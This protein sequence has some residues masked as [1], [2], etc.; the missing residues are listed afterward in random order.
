MDAGDLAFFRAVASAGGMSKAAVMLNTVQSNVTQRIRLLETELGVPLFHRHTRGVSL[1]SAG[2]Q[3]LPYAERIGRLIGEAKQAAADGPVPRGRIVIGSLE[4]TAALRLPPILAAYAS[5]YP[6]VDIE[7]D[8]GTSAELIEAVLAHKVEAA[9]VVGPVNHPELV[10]LPMI[11][12]E[13]VLV[14]ASWIEDLGALQASRRF[15]IIVFRAGCTYRVHLEA[16]LA[17]QGIVG[18]RRLEFGTLEG[19]IGCVGA[20]I[21]VTLL[22]RAVVAAAAA[23]GRVALHPL[24]PQDARAETVLV[25]RRDAFASS[26]LL[27]F[28]EK[29]TEVC[30]GKQN[31]QARVL[32]KVSKTRAR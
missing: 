4:T 7:I 5:T 12:E 26:A 2:A 11:E 18:L 27:R 23:E 32:Q 24:P 17:R 6:D 15:K 19:I 1:T 9:F 13:L 22:P 8:T 14:T 25:R 31:G 3:L 30:R 16:L 29:A 21:G 10:S 28:I 20:G